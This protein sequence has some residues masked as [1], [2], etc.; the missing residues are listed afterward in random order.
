MHELGGRV[1][2]P[3]G[4]LWGDAQNGHGAARTLRATPGRSI[5]PGPPPGKL[6]MLPGG[7][8]DL[9]DYLAGRPHH[10]GRHIDDPTPG[11]IVSVA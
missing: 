8:G 9:E 3:G 2:L 7:S 4:G 6:A 11:K 10:L 5:A 1:W